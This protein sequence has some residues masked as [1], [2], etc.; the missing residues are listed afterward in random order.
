MG[1]GPEIGED[2]EEG[3]E[4]DAL[5]KL[6]LASNGPHTAKYHIDKKRKIKSLIT[7]V[8]T[9]HS[10][11]RGT[12][13]MPLNLAIPPYT[14]HSQLLSPLSINAKKILSCLDYPVS[15]WL[16]FMVVCYFL[17]LHWCEVAVAFLL[18]SLFSVLGC[19]GESMHLSGFPCCWMGVYYCLFVLYILILLR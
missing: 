17:R 9:H 16:L 5:F 13:V 11:L 12:M 15:L 6:S 4:G 19:H 1:G 14:S 18:L 3:E 2:E 7:E 10:C 8:P